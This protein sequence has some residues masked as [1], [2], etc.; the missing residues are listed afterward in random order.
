M[1]VRLK[2]G[3]M[4]RGEKDFDRHYARYSYKD[5]WFLS[6]ADVWYQSNNGPKNN[7]IRMELFP[8]GVTYKGITAKWFVGMVLMVLYAWKGSW[9]KGIF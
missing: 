6:S 1:P 5:G 4:F 8:L 2:L 7:Q 3:Y 9:R